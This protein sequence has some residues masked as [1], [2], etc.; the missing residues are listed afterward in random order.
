V[1]RR[2]L[3]ALFAGIAAALL[4]LSVYAFAG[5]GGSAGRL[6]VGVAALALALWLGSLALSGL[7][8]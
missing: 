6:I 7:R 4:A 5:A 8:G 3:G 1:Q 2:A